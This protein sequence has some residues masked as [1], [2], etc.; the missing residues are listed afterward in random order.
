MHTEP[1]VLRKVAARKREVLKGL[2]SEYTVGV[3]EKGKGGLRHTGMY[4][5]PTVAS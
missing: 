1:G 3:R 4:W 2:I 5:R